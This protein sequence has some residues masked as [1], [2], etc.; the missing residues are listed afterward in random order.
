MDLVEVLRSVHV[1][2][3]LS[4]GQ[5]QRLQDLLT[6]VTFKDGEYVIRQGDQPDNGYIIAE[7][8][9]RVTTGQ[10]TLMELGQGQY[11]GE[12]ALLSNEP[13]AANVI[14]MGESTLKLLCISK[15]AYEEV[16]GPL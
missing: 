8:R 6:E 2:K 10:M 7:G 3:S 15:E 12:R 13:R 1:L 5:L 9:V 14:A 4:V 11:F 16:R